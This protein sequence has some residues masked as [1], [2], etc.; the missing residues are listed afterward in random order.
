MY[1]IRVL[2][3]ATIMTRILCRLVDYGD[4][5]DIEDGEIYDRGNNQDKECIAKIANI[6]LK[7]NQYGTLYS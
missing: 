1:E 4:D 6:P 7:V 3:M 5:D 2:T